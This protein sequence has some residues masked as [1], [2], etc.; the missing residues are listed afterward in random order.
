MAPLEIGLW[1]GVLIGATGSGGAWLG[2]FASDRLGRL[3]AGWTL[4]APALALLAA[5]PFAAGFLFL[6]TP[7]LALASFAPFYLLS[8]AYVGP[9]WSALQGISRLRMRATV[10]A[11]FQ[12]VLNLIG[13]GLGP[14]LVGLL[15]DELAARFGDKAIR[16]SLALVTLLG[17]AGAVF[18]LR[19]SRTLPGDLAARDA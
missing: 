11:L 5:L 16:W 18:L 10:A 15:N 19:A 12:F 7:A 6:P 2:G 13:L 1:L 8:N 4:R 3:G 17:A 9:V 14:L